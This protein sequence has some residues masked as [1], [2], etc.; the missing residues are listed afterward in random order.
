MDSK[1]NKEKHEFIPMGKTV[2]YFIN[3]LP[4]A[5]ISEINFDKERKK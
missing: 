2:L 5:L 4:R 1:E 3:P